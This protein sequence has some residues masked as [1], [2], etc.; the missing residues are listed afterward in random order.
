MESRGIRGGGG[1]Q[2]RNKRLLSLL[3]YSVV[4]VPYCAAFLF[5]LLFVEL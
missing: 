1:E 5:A 3:R 2:S 4:L